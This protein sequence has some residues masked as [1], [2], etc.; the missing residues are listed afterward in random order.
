MALRRDI[1]ENWFKKQ[2]E[3]CQRGEKDYGYP[4]YGHDADHS[5]IRFMPGGSAMNILTDS[6]FNENPELIDIIYGPGQDTNAT[7]RRAIM[8][9]RDNG[10]TGARTIL[11]VIFCYGNL[12]MLRQFRH[13]TKTDKDLPFDKETCHIFDGDVEATFYESQF[14]FVPFVLREGVYDDTT[15]VNSRS[16][17]EKI[18]EPYISR[19][20]I[21]E[22]SYGTTFRVTVAQHHYQSR[23]TAPSANDRVTY[24][25][26]VKVEEYS[27]NGIVADLPCDQTVQ[28]QFKACAA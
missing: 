18:R 13:C 9:E 5:R 15:N 24:Y 8:G 20:Q 11:L 14:E 6:W 17:H 22:G 26:L 7:K 28:G 12:Q 10:N 3:H 1:D 21:G 19:D 25:E 27:I 2:K 4:G 23:T 16:G